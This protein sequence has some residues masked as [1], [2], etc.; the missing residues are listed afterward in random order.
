[1]GVF[2]NISKFRV[3]VVERQGFKMQEQG[4][5]MESGF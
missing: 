5:W 3:G 2:V 4:Y 1:M